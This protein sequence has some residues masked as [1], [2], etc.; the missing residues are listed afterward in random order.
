[1]LMST[2]VYGS[3]KTTFKNW[4]CA[5][6]MWVQILKLCH[7]QGSLQMGQPYQLPAYVLLVVYVGFELRHIL[8]VTTEG[9]D[10]GW[11]YAAF[12]ST[13]SCHCFLFIVLFFVLFVCFAFVIHCESGTVNYGVKGSDG[14]DISRV[15]YSLLSI[16]FMFPQLPPLT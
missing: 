9:Q 14:G 3:Q 2:P 1:M 12:C 5:S 13:L 11:H 10:T 7:Q 16:P 6:T 8:L 15:I 4:F